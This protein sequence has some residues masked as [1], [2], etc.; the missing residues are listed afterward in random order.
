M[1]LSL[2]DQLLQAGL[3]SQKQVNEAERQEQRQKQQA[4]HAKNGPK[5]KRPPLVEPPP[6]RSVDPV[7]LARDQ[8][9]NRRKQEKAQKKAL[10]AQIKQLIEQNRLPPLEGG[11]PYSFLD[12]NKIRRIAVSAAARARLGRGDL[13]I[14]RHDG[15]YDLVP[16]TIAARIRERDERAVVPLTVAPETPPVDEAYQKFTVPDDLIW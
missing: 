15:G 3:V 1:S 5:H 11:E 4:H 12:G 13:T 7:K 10:A 9:L 14:V 2:R 16:A 6:A 8:E